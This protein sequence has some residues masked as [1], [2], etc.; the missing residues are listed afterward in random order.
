VLSQGHRQVNRPRFSVSN[1]A[2]D[3]CTMTY[4]RRRYLPLPATVSS[5]QACYIAGVATHLRRCNVLI[6][7]LVKNFQ[8]FPCLACRTLQPTF[9]VSLDNKLLAHVSRGNTVVVLSKAITGF[10]KLEMVHQARMLPARQFADIEVACATLCL[11][12]T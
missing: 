5:T 1:L 12:S 7:H 9:P 11:G 8:G 4:P 10:G 2:G 3:A 6:G